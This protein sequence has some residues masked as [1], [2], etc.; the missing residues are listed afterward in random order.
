MNGNNPANLSVGDT[1]SDLGATITGPAG[2]TNLGISASVDGG[3]ATTPAQVSLDTSAAG[4]HTIVY[5]A[6]DQHGVIGTATRTVIVAGRDATSSPGR[7]TDAT[8][9]V[10]TLHGDATV[11]LTV[12]DA[13][14]EPGATATDD[15][16]GN[17]TSDIIETGSVDTSTAGA[18]T[19]TYSATDAA[20][21]TRS[22]TRTVIVSAAADTGPATP[23]DSEAA[24]STDTTGGAN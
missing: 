22:A 20:G 15:T 8:A 9:P 17:L 6:T 7:P 4:T 3:A 2:D 5:S 18:Y 13:W 24:T 10:V 23:T 12:G 21:N 14:T 1:Y 16:D 11:A 19:L